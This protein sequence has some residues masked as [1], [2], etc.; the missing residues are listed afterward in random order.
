MPT[1]FPAKSI[2][3]GLALIIKIYLVAEMSVFI[4]LG[5]TC[6]LAVKSTARGGRRLVRAFRRLTEYPL[7]RSI[8]S[9]FGIYTSLHSL[10]LGI[11]DI[12]GDVSC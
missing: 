5:G 9:R 1:V 3:H 10:T 11:R 7:W 2:C 6:R 4:F 12:T 8:T